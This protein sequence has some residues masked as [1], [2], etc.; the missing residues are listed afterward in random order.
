MKERKIEILKLLG[1]IYLATTFIY[2][3][4]FIAFVA[5]IL[6]DF[7]LGSITVVAVASAYLIEQYM[8]HLIST[9]APDIVEELEK[10]RER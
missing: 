6:F 5:F 2:I 8:M 10:G 9:Q 7:S 1:I 4:A 3:N